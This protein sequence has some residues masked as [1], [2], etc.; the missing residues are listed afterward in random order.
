MGTENA[1]ATLERGERYTYEIVRVVTRPDGSLDHGRTVML[2][3]SNL[4][5]DERATLH[6]LVGI[7]DTVGGCEQLDAASMLNWID[8]TFKDWRADAERDAERARDWVAEAVETLEH[9]DDEFGPTL[10]RIV[11][12]PCEGREDGR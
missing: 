10:R 8:G 2:D 11:G 12:E 1:Y 4:W 5:D 6:R 3:G 7:L 9:L